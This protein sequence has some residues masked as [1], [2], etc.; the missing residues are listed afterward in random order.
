[1]TYLAVGDHGLRIVD[2]RVP[3]D[4]REISAYS[5]DGTLFE[6]DL[7]GHLAYLSYGTGGVHVLDVTWP[8][9]PKPVSVTKPWDSVRGLS[10]YGQHA[11]C[12][13]GNDGFGVLDL[14]TPAAPLA[15]RILRN[16]LPIQ[17]DS[18]APAATVAH[19]IYPTT[20]RLRK[21]MLETL[22]R[23]VATGRTLVFTRTTDDTCADAVVIKD[24]KLE[25]KLPLKTEVAIQIPAGEAKTYEFACGMGMYKSKIVVE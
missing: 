6:V 16:P 14:S 24:L 17:V 8:A 11:Y 7:Q 10:L 15:V 2:V 13:L 19:S 12:A 9:A 22:L 25:K 23:R 5:T 21:S 4:P 1:M 3:K 18:I 20:D